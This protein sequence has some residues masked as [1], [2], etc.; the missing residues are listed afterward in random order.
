MHGLCTMSTKTISLETD[1][2]QLLKREKQPRESFSQ[3]V[4]RIVRERPA[5]TAG[6]LEE[7]MKIFEGHGAG[8]KRAKRRAVA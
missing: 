4:R 5:L 6:E 1:A 2:Y 7:A 8:P 3:A